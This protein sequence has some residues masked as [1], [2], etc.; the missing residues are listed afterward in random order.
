M[1]IYPICG[2]KQQSMQRNPDFVDTLS[3]SWK[4]IPRHSQASQK[5]YVLQHVL[6][7]SGPPLS[8]TCLEH[9]PGAASR[10][11]QKRIQSLISIWMS[12]SSTLSSCRMTELLSLPLRNSYKCYID[13]IL[14]YY[15]YSFKNIVLSGRLRNVIVRAESIYSVFFLSP[16][17]VP[18]LSYTV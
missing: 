11:H 17:G 6:G 4:R 7:F 15:Y 16:E 10:R 8:G 13:K 9:L 18:T 5:T 3:R 2:E 12:S 1:Q 14:Y